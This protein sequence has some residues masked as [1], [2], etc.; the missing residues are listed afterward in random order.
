MEVAPPPA[1]PSSIPP[2]K[3]LGRP[4]GRKNQSTSLGAVGTIKKNRKVTQSKGPPK[5]RTTTA[6]IS[7]AKAAPPMVSTA[8]T[9]RP[10]STII[11]PTARRSVDFRPPPNPAP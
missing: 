1:D 8:L 2:K 5:R 6:R 9:P 11:P 3:R 10:S 4:P 7:K